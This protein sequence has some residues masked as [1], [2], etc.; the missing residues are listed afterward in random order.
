MGRALIGTHG[1]RLELFA[2]YLG[3]D[4]AQKQTVKAL[5]E[6]ARQDAQPIVEQLRAG[7]EEMRAALTG[8]KSESEIGAL[9]A[10]QGT[11][12]GQLAAIHAMQF[13]K[14]YQ[15]LTP[16]QKEKAQTLHDTVIARFRDRWATRN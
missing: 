4:E 5:A 7:H 14:L 2:G 9:A 15:Q 11:L 8:G 12:M 1:A 16:E 13:A 6:Q 10:R 3:L